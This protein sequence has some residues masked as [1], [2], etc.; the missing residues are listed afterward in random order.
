MDKK[1]KVAIADDHPM[2]IEG[3]VNYLKS[4]PDIEVV[5]TASKVAEVPKMIKNSCPDIL[6][7][8]YHFSGEG[9]TGI[10]MC[11]QVKN[12]YPQIGVIIISSFSDVPLIRKAIELGASGY[13]IKTATKSEFVEAI[14][15]VYLGLDAFS[16]DVRDL[17]IKDKL[18]AN[19]TS[20][21]RFTKTEKDILKLIIEGLSSEEIAKHLYREK[22]TIDTHRKS[23]LSKLQQMDNDCG[24]GSKNI[25]HYIAKLNIANRIDFL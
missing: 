22:S 10:E 12:E 14:H 17:L 16:K 3:L 1:I 5:D 4:T 18:Q 23:I 8:D 2:V 25:S 21:I 11:L 19:R 15:N 9:Q 13:I 20:E 24:G 7:M 6:L